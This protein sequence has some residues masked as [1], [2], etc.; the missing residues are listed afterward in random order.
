MKF[1]PVDK[2]READAFTIAN[3]PIASIDLMERA[4]GQL[5][6]W[7]AS[8]YTT[9]SCYRIF[10]GPGNNGGDAWALA[11]LL[12]HKGYKHISFFLLDTGRSL[13]SDSEINRT[14]LEKETDIPVHAICNRKDFP[15]IEATDI[16][17]DGLFG[18]GLSRSP[19]G[20][21]SEL[22]QYIN[23]RQ[24]LALIAIDVPSGLF[25]EDNSGNRNESIIQATYTLT[26]QFPKLSFF[27]P[28]NANFAG[29]WVVL[30]IG[31]HPEFIA[32]EN[33]IYNYMV[34]SDATG[35]LQPR[36]K[37]S[38]KGTYGH[39][40][41]IA[42]SYGMMGA[43]VLSA[44]AA[45]RSGPGLLT[46]HTPRR[47]V[48]ILQTT[49]PEALLSID[50]SDI[51]FTGNTLPEKYSCVAIGPGINQKT[52]TRKALPGLLNDIQVPLIIDADGLNIL[53]SL[54]NWPELLPENTILTPHP[55]E[56][57]R[58]FGKFKNS[59]SR[60]QFQ[61]T[62]SMDHQCVIVLKGANTCITMPSGEIWFNTTGNPGMATGGSGDVLTGI[63][64]GLLA[65]GYS[66]SNAA[67][68]GTYIHGMAGDISAECCGQHGLIASDIVD[69]IG[70]AFYVLEKNRR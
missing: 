31:L 52:N 20:L 38:H 17:L 26:F 70:S 65:Q 2:I 25:C 19:D 63:L 7:I 37:F 56:F 32:K 48:E 29:E 18:S 54:E 62:F 16:L 10:A 15:E 46:V 12:W 9:E 58:L 30:P 22:I 1:F 6:G 28:E 36:D 66:I 41:L 60:M 55:K 24:K 5:A 44:R 45:L 69:N 51:L 59:F 3:E 57:E 27:F 49:V 43:A 23:K 50:E 33:T 61:R 14:R 4:A 64:L 68:L 47:G 39:A 42:G 67:I 35:L 13:S 53:A 11:R 21:A 8:K 34:E 40:L